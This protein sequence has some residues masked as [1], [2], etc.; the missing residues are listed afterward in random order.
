MDE[1]LQGYT[2]AVIEGLGPQQLATVAGELEGFLALLASSGDLR[3]VITGPGNPVPVRRA[4]IHELLAPR[5]S[6][7]SLALLEFAVAN[8]TSA[9]YVEDV[10]G[11]EAAV[12]AR[13]EGMVLLDEG[14]LGRTAAAER[15]DGYATAVLSPVGERA[16]GDIEDELFRFMRVVDGSSELCAALTTSELPAPVRQSVVEDLLARRSRPESVRLASYAVRFGRPRDYLVLLETLVQ[17]VAGEA[18]RRVADVR[19]AV[20]MSEADRRRLAV[21]LGRLTGRE[22]DVRVTLEPGLLGGFVATIGDT[23]VD[24]SV[25]HR[26]EQ[27]KELLFAPPARLPGPPVPGPDGP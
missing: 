18:N 1:R 4:V 8:V 10:A 24:A 19:S 22:V 23:V 5:V 15:L 12:S 7:P 11:I 16:L 27:A 6:A 3:A 21:A 20:D 25:R 2:D 26:L 9:D 17:R 13:R 14:P